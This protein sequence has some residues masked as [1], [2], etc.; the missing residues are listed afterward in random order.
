MTDGAASAPQRRAE[1]RARR[2]DALR[3]LPFLGAVLFVAPDL[4]LSDGG[5]GAT[6]PWLRYLFASWLIL[7]GLA[8]WLAQAH[9]R[10][11]PDGAGE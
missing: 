7:I 9:L 2:A 10:D 11:L 8:L 1:G 5:S 6:L 3:M 4:V